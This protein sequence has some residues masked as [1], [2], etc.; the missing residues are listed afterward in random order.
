MQLTTNNPRGIQSHKIVSK[1]YV[2]IIAGYN[3][4]K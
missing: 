2:I 4:V 3:A 1:Y